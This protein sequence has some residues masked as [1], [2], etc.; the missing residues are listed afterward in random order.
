MLRKTLLFFFTVLGLQAQSPLRV[1]TRVGFIGAS[2]KTPF[3]LRS[4]RYGLVPETSYL[5]YLNARVYKE[6]DTLQANGQQK[7]FDYG[8]ALEPHLNTGKTTQFLFPEVYAKGRW[9]FIEMYGGR[10]REIVGLTDTLLTSGSY[11]WSGNALP[12]WKIQVGIPEYTPLLKSGL[13]SI[14][15]AM[16]HGW[17]DNDRPVT[18]NVKLHQKWLYMRL[19]KPEWKVKIHAGFNHQVQWGGESPFFT[20]NGK[21]PDGWANFPYVFFGTRNP[22]SSTPLA[23]F[24]GENRI[25]NHLGTIDISLD[26]QTAFGEVMV[27]R[28]SIYEDGSLFSLNNIADGLNGLSVK[29]N[30]LP[31]FRRINLEYLYTASQGGNVFVV[32]KDAPRELR[33]ADNYFNHA[34]FRDGW[35]Y[36]GMIIGTPYIQTL[37]KSWDDPEYQ[38][39]H[40]RVKMFQW[41]LAGVLPFKINYVLKGN[42]S[43]NWGSYRFPTIATPQSSFLLALQKTRPRSSTIRLEFGYDYGHLLPNSMGI[44]IHYIKNWK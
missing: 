22:D 40:N 15:G 16:V 4:N 29:L 24:D 12:L 19:G 14:K 43:T 9:K 21:L 38:I 6:Y 37:N 2:E 18:R 20:I 1:E 33:G 23:G 13:V 31:L 10:R 44:A 8:F 41:A 25:G 42:H 36:K 26:F 30:D 7:I 3:L 27:Y 32:G 28:Q 11:I 35:T 17:F 5:L 39:D 34:Q